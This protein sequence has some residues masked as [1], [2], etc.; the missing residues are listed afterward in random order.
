MLLA[1]PEHTSSPE[2]IPEAPLLAPLQISVRTSLWLTSMLSFFQAYTQIECATPRRCWHRRAK[3]ESLLPIGA[4]RLRYR[5]PAP[6]LQR[7]RTLSATTCSASSETAR[8][9]GPC[10]PFAHAAALPPTPAQHPQIDLV[11]ATVVSSNFPLSCVEF[12][13]LPTGPQ[14]KR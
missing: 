3:N 13:S 6:A 5:Q 4:C 2:L 1:L 10:L 14:G 7:L 8:P 9:P 12:A 11:E